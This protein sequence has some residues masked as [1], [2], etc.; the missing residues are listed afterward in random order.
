MTE[1]RA[2][3]VT[4]PKKG[5]RPNIERCSEVRGFGVIAY[6][7][8][9]RSYFVEPS[10]TPRR[11]LGIVGILHFEGPADDPGALNMAKAALAAARL[12]KN[13]DEAIGR[14]KSPKD[15]VTLND[16][17]AKY[18]ELGYPKVR[19]D[20]NKRPSTLASDSDR[21]KRYVEKTIGK[22]RIGDIS[23]ATVQ[24]WLDTITKRGQRD[25]CL[26]LV[27]SILSFADQRKIAEPQRIKLKP[28]KTKKMQNF[29]APEDLI[30]LDQA[31]ADLA[32]EQ[33]SRLAVFSALRLILRTGARAGEIFSLRWQDADLRNA[34]L[35]LERDKT[36]DDGRD[37]YLDEEAV[38]I[39]QGLPRINK[40]VFPSESKR[41]HLTT[42]QGAWEEVVAKAGVRRF[43]IHDLRHSF[44]SAAI[45]NGVSLY[46]VGKLLGHRQAT[47][48]QRYA[49]LEDEAARAA[50]GKVSSVLSPKASLKDE[51]NESA[52]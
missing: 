30:A 5:E 39:L 36:S 35:I 21:W 51:M 9:R 11:V 28:G 10:R 50:L 26:V 12:G 47:T 49:H 16:A 29:Y 31:A 2:M 13:T 40:W 48:T 14:K 1:P 52:A 32:A 41:G 22:R 33:P 43:R 37:V 15:K 23:E 18:E 44:A 34:K 42:V 20:G 27:K 7:S 17:W 38:K 45:N 8:G 4:L 46:V 6:E 3:K 24:N 19:G 25:H